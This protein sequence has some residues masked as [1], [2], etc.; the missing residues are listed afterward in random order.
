VSIH[1]TPRT[2]F[3]IERDNPCGIARDQEMLPGPESNQRHCD[4]HREA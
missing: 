1:G 3:N 2:I 4:F